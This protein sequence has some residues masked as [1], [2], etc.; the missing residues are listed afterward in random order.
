[1]QRWL[2][3]P[4]TRRLVV[5]GVTMT[6][7][8]LSRYEA[9]PVAALSVLI[10]ALAGRGAWKIKLTNA[11][12]FAALVAVGPLYWLWHNWA[13][14]G[15]A[16]EFLSGPHSARAIFLHEEARLGWAKVFIGHPL[17]SLVWMAV[18]TAVCNGPFVLLLSTVGFVIFITR[19]RRALLEQSPALLLAVPFLFH[20]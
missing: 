13:I 18:T 2:N 3:E 12:L 14:F 5:A 8:T 1:L 20:A 15:N 9:W 19:K 4:T 17:V 6:L 10:V 16:L 11:T 7:A